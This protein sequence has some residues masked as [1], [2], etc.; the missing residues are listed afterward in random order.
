MLA[1]GL[2]AGNDEL[3]SFGKRVLFIY[4]FVL[5]TAALNHRRGPDVVKQS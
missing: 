5:K 3:N 1:C 4:L 2:A